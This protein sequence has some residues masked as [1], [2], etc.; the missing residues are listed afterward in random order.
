MAE[1]IVK[2]LIVANYTSPESFFQ[3]YMKTHGI[4]LYEEFRRALDEIQISIYHEEEEIK[5]FFSHIE[6]KENKGAM[7]SGSNN[8]SKI[9]LA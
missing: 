5:D 2:S 7:T 6:M 9:S 8:F 3:K 1:D 4:I